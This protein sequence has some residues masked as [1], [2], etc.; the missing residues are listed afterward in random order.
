MS[1]QQ[2]GRRIGQNLVEA[3]QPARYVAVLTA[4]YGVQ[5]WPTAVIVVPAA[6]HLP[7]REPNHDLVVRFT[8]E[9]NQFQPDAIDFA[10]DLVL[11]VDGRRLPESSGLPVGEP[12]AYP[13]ALGDVFF[14]AQCIPE[15]PDAAQVLDILQHFRFLQ[16][17]GCWREGDDFRVRTGKR[18]GSAPVIRVAVRIQDGLNRLFSPAPDNLQQLLPPLQRIERIDQDDAGAA[19]DDDGVAVAYAEDMPNAGHNGR[20]RFLIR[21]FR[22]YSEFCCSVWLQHGL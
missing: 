12:F 10:D 7:L 9:P 15:L 6:Q 20:Y 4:A 2:V 18:P 5:V 21:F 17:G 3:V 1:G 19:F 16:H 13:D 11:I 8:G 22:K 14:I